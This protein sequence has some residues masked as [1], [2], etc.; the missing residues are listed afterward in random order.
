[1]L[2][3]SA[4]RR[5]GQFGTRRNGSA[6]I[7]AIFHGQFQ[8]FSPNRNRTNI[9]DLRARY[10]CRSGRGPCFYRHSWHVD[11]AYPMVN[12]RREAQ[13]RLLHETRQPAARIRARD[14]GCR[15]RRN[16]SRCATAR[17]GI[18]SIHQ[19]MR[20]RRLWRLIGHRLHSKRHQVWSAPS[21]VRLANITPV[22][23]ELIRRQRFHLHRCSSEA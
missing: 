10:P 8:R 7:D 16:L 4:I 12:A 9:N 5:G 19:L 13:P 6:P 18:G 3:V 1:V 20:R 21:I 14:G 2:I 11:Q 15:T 17:T 23:T 22:H